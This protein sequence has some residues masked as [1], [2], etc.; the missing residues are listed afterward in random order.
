MG[1]SNQER[2]VGRPGCGSPAARPCEHNARPR[3]RHIEH[4]DESKGRL[5]T[6]LQSHAVGRLHF[7]KGY[8]LREMAVTSC[9]LQ[10]GLYAAD[11]SSPIGSLEVPRKPRPA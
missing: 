3:S 10:S 7:D 9:S 11:S 2:E 1:A 4:Y 8:L 6:I 5:R